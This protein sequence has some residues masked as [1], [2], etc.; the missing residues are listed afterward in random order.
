[1]LYDGL[2]GFCNGTVQFILARDRAQ[3]M[4]FATLQG[5]YAAQIVAEHPE[6]GAVDSVIL[7]VRDEQGERFL[8]KSA[9]VLEVARYLGW[10]WKVLLIN[11]ILPRFMRDAGYDLFARV[12]YGLF[13]KY[14]SCPIPDAA[15][16][17]RFID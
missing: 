15:V 14:N 11:R 1:M 3:T 5:R 9:A 12:R 8:V 7:V 10:P 13:G 4:R 2:C 17:E 16:R 6:L